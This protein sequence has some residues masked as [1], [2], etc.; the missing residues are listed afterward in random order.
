LFLFLFTKNK[1]R[2]QSIIKQLI[3]RIDWF[4]ELSRK[5]GKPFD[6]NLAVRV[7][8]ADRK[9]AHAANVFMREAEAKVTELLVQ[10]QKSFDE[11]RKLQRKGVQ[12]P[13]SPELRMCIEK[14]GFA[15]RPMMIKRDRCICDQ[16]HVEVSGWRPWHDP[17]KFHNYDR[18]DSA[19]KGKEKEKE[20]ARNLMMELTDGN[21]GKTVLNTD[22]NTSSTDAKTSTTTTTTTSMTVNDSC[23]TST[24]VPNVLLK[25]VIDIDNE[26]TSSTQSTL[27]AAQIL[28]SLSSSLPKSKQLPH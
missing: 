27:S 21:S 1:V 23:V 12:W 19:F 17:W 3:Q 28:M 10:N 5:S 26:K 13:H 11:F 24:D 8:A 25:T 15:F 14:A 18:H 7:I 16:C 4:L 6:P 22:T 9:W 20:K 2:G